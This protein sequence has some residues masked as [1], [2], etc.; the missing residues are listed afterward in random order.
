MKRISFLTLILLNFWVFSLSAESIKVYFIKGP[1]DNFY[2]IEEL[3][4]IEITTSYFG[5]NIGGRAYL[6]PPFPEEINKFDVIILGSIRLDSLNIKERLLLRNFVK[7]GGALLFLG[8]YFS[9]GKSKI[10][11][12]FLEEM[13]PVNLSSHFDLIPLAEPAIKISTNSI[14][15]DIP[16][17]E[18]ICCLWAHRVLPKEGTEVILRAGNIPLLIIGNYGKGKTAAFTGTPLGIPPQDLTPFW[19]W[20]AWP[21]FLSEVIKYL[22]E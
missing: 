10:E 5:I 8:G 11:K 6:E 16:W 2:Q 1:W 22:T 3:E 21:V 18:K 7:E 14:F 9:Y 15:K 12:T 19:E 17:N 20:K 4:G 13:L